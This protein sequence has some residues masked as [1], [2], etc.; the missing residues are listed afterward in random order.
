[1][2]CQRCGLLAREPTPDAAE[3]LRW[4]RDQYWKQYAAE[5]CGSARDNL[6]ERVLD[7]LAARLPEP[8]TLVDV[9]CGMGALLAQARQLGW[10]AIGFDPSPS[11]V[12][13]AR[14]QGLDARES[15]WPPCELPNESVDAVVFLNV[16]D[17]LPSPF[18]ALEE[19][20]RVLRPHGCVYIRLPNVPL[21]VLSSRVLSLIGLEDVTIMHLYGFGRRALRHHLT[22]LG[23]DN[24]VIRAAPPSRQ[25]AYQRAGS[26]RWGSRSWLKSLDRAVYRVSA[27]TG[28]DRLAWGPSIEAMASKGPP[29]ARV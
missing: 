21:H 8:G 22:R 7:C 16:L 11:A 26:S 1:M 2:R 29:P 13:E 5:Q 3:L 25:D 17:H 15:A 27:V 6:Y 12:A 24:V 20:R 14:A 23:F 28:L 18:G 10:Q 19:A 9:G 4:Y